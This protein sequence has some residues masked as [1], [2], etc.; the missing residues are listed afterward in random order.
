[1][2]CL[3]LN[4]SSLAEQF[5]EKK[6]KQMVEGEDVE[7]SS[8]QWCASKELRNCVGGYIISNRIMEIQFIFILAGD[9]L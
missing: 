6:N 2:L 8:F 5:G 7:W 1:M 9:L 3:I 4:I